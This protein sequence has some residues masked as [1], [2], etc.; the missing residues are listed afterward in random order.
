M[1]V[2]VGRT[3]RHA[4]TPPSSAAAFL[5]FLHDLVPHLRKRI[6]LPFSSHTSFVSTD[7]KAF[8]ARVISYYLSLALPETMGLWSV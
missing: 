8:Q 2:E 1:A 4:G 7:R 6:L 5:H 3:D